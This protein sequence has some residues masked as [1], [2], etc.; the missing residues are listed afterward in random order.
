M[1]RASSSRLTMCFAS[2][3]E[4]SPISAAF[5]N[6]CAVYFFIL[7]IFYVNSSQKRIN[8]LIAKSFSDLG[9]ARGCDGSKHEIANP[10]NMPLMLSRMINSRLSGISF[11]VIKYIVLFI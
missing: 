2:I 8:I 6:S 11:I 5:K 3:I 7:L 1:R 4:T 9:M 10:D